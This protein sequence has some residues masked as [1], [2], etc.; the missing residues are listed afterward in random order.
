MDVVT[1]R[2]GGG[3]LILDKEVALKLRPPDEKQPSQQG[4]G[5]SQQ[6]PR[7]GKALGQLVE[8]AR[9]P[10]GGWR[11]VTRG[12]EGCDEGGGVGRQEAEHQRPFHVVC[13][14]KFRFSSKNSL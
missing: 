1:G 10:T 14:G 13:R 4:A 9:L 5:Y 3:E 2:T 8:A 6:I 7:G 11:A 12:R